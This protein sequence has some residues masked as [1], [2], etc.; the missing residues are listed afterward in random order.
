MEEWYSR[1][2]DSV[3]FDGEEGE[4]SGWYEEYLSGGNLTYCGKAKRAGG[5][6]FR[7][8]E[9]KSFAR[10][11]KEKGYPHWGAYRMVKANMKAS[12]SSFAKY[13]RPQPD[14]DVGAWAVA[15]EW[16]KEHWHH[17]MGGAKVVDKETVLSEMDMSTSGGFP[18]SKKFQN[19]RDMLKDQKAAAVLDAY[20]DLICKEITDIV[21]IWTCSQKV[22]LRDLKKLLLNR[23]R[24][25]TA[26]PFEHSCSLNRL[27]LDMN[28]KFYA[29]GARGDTWSFVGG[30]KF[31][32]GWDRLFRRLN[33][34][35]NA[36]E[37]D[38]SDYDA[39]LFADALYGQMEIRWSFLREEDRTPENRRALENLYNSIV[40]SLVVLE[41][42]ELVQKHGGNPSG[43]SNTIV[44]NT[45]ILYRLFA[46]A[47]I[48]LCK[49][50]GV[51]PS[52]AEFEEHV[53]A[54]LNGDDNSYTV[55]DNV[56]GWFT[57]F[58]IKRIWGS[59]GVTTKTPCDQP[60]KLE[61]ISFLSQQ[62]VYDNGMG[63]WI[64][65]PSTDRVLSSL[66]WGSPNDDVRW[67][68]LRAC[69]LRLDSYGNK[70]ARKILSEYIE[71]LNKEYAD[72]LVGEV[73]INDMTEPIT[74]KQIRSVWKSDAWIEAL[75]GGKE[76]QTEY[77]SA[78]D[79]IL[80]ELIKRS[81]I[82]ENIEKIDYLNETKQS[83]IMPRTEAQRAKRREKRRARRA[84]KTQ[85]NNQQK[86]TKLQ[87][88]AQSIRDKLAS[89]R[90]N[91]RP[92]GVK[93]GPLPRGAVPAAVAIAGMANL[94][95]RP[96][97]KSRDERSRQ[98]AAASSS[99]GAAIPAGN[100][101]M[102]RPVGMIQSMIR[103]RKL[104][105]AQAA[106]MLTRSILAPGVMPAPHMGSPGMATRVYRTTALIYKTPIQFG[107]TG[108]YGLGAVAFPALDG[109]MYLSS[110][111]NL[112]STAWSLVGNFTN[113][114]YNASS[115]FSSSLSG[116]RLLG[117]SL[118][119]TVSQPDTFAKPYVTLLTTKCQTTNTNF[120]AAL[121]HDLLAG[122]N[123]R[124]PVVGGDSAKQVRAVSVPEPRS[125]SFNFTSNIVSTG[126]G[127]YHSSWSV[128]LIYMWWL[129][130]VNSAGAS[131]VAGI[132]V[133]LQ[134]TY[135]F[136]GLADIT[137]MTSSLMDEDDPSSDEVLDTDGVV[138]KL[139]VRA[140]A[141]GALQIGKFAMAPVATVAGSIASAL[142]G[143]GD[144]PGPPPVLQPDDQNAV[145]HRVERLEELVSAS[146]T[147]A[148]GS[149]DV[150]KYDYHSRLEREMEAKLSSSLP[151]TGE[152][153]EALPVPDE[154]YRRFTV[155]SHLQGR[156]PS[157]DPSSLGSSRSPLTQIKSP[158][159]ANQQRG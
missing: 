94:P 97:R 32:C 16:T 53:E 78:V 107:T 100:F 23:V 39:S 55:S 82:K 60:R 46:Y 6:R 115:T 84:G 10:F 142:V 83:L 68:Y 34:H 139:D 54:A 62:F 113:A 150:K 111:P 37:L 71:F 141:K 128:P 149:Q 96:A 14:Y 24:T 119:A 112:T 114:P 147:K 31:L 57:T 2:L 126:T 156:I 19:K 135:V 9:N 159:G 127:A 64:P 131:S 130:P 1:F 157:G 98:D 38:E 103:D 152:E 104:T 58:A 13:D 105:T 49:E 124:N 20:W 145:E 90:G 12:F 35:P 61:D 118:E 133:K 52:R 47:W 75:L 129:G 79:G 48:M 154:E 116:G 93:Y 76:G 66:M 45:M 25:F 134:W 151:L 8:V 88:E 18:W 122:S 158:V 65:S 125:E 92:K 36:F 85:G 51:L 155:P 29:A 63:I 140:L 148:P 40:H 7:E 121:S 67:H 56:V 136:E 27:C 144:E 77:R 81:P 106:V 110:L 89:M 120:A 44:D 70:V 42:G 17:V 123:F 73:R 30:T 4:R 26:S 59:I 33:K 3:I 109:A 137:K 43:S 108:H 91:A 28:D 102:Q 87:R 69:A 101:A 21:P 86:P 74:M 146:G 72:E 117:M 11:C 132:T 80:G 138:D 95:Q 15:G 41:T 5:Y 50:R 153:L 143:V 99:V 22:E